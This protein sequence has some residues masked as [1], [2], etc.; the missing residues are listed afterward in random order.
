MSEVSPTLVE[1][2][3]T[4][5]EKYI[6]PDNK[7]EKVSIPVTTTNIKS[8]LN[9]KPT[10][11][12][13]QMKL[14]FGMSPAVE[15][16]LLKRK[17]DD[18]SIMAIKKKAKFKPTGI[19]ESMLVEGVAFFTNEKKCKKI[20]ILMRPKDDASPNNTIESEK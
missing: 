7:E 5:E 18:V 4:I 6:L 3:P 2:P 10:K 11:K 8:D 19:T 17:G 9:V 20:F 15:K 16:T 1:N 14:P 12:K 13:V